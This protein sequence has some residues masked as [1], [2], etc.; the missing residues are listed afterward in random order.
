VNANYSPSEDL[1]AWDSVASEYAAAVGAGHPIIE[2]FRPFLS[3]FIGHPEGLEVLDVGCGQGWLAGELA[4]K[5][6]RVTGVDG[7]A[8]LLKFA[9]SAYPAVEFYQ[10]DLTGGLPKELIERRFDRVVT[11]MVLMDVSSLDRLLTDLRRCL[12]PEGRFLIA[13]THPAFWSQRP[14]EDPDT[15]ERYRKVRGYLEPEERWV[16]GFGGH[17]H[18]HR[19]LGWYVKALVRNGLAITEL[20]EP[21]NPPADGRP[22]GAWTD[23]DRWFATIPTMLGLLAAPHG[24]WAGR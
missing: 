3:D 10:A 17:R 13:M 5:G 4:A 22:S 16:T 15:G 21:P 19:P 8:E 24:H 18:Y 12:C 2:R 7:S 9:R 14:M 6:A 20:F 23:Y 1:A 11:F